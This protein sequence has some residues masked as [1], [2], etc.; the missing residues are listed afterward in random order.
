MS[1]LCGDFN[2]LPDSE[3]LALLRAAGFRELVTDGGF[4]T[5]RTSHYDKPPLFADYMLINQ[6]EVVLAFNVVTTPEVSDHCP[7]VMTL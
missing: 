2:V 7:L 4:A 5:T 1:V 6:P 3:N